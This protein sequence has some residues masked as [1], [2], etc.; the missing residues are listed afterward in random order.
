MKIR[1]AGMLE[2]SLT[3]GK[4]IR[5]VIFGQGCKHNCEECFNRHTHDFNG[6]IEMDTSEIINKINDDIYIDG[7]TFSGGDPFEQAEAFSNIA[8][9]TICNIWC[10]TGYTFEYILEN[11]DKNPGWNDLLNNIDVLVDGK[12]IIELRS[13]DLKYRGSLNQRI[14]DVKKSLELNRVEYYFLSNNDMKIEHMRDLICFYYSNIKK[15]YNII[16]KKNLKYLINPYER[17]LNKFKDIHIENDINLSLDDIKEFAGCCK[18]LVDHLF[19]DSSEIDDYQRFNNL[20]SLYS[21]DID[22]IIKICSNK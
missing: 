13:K 19:I 18:V 4:G 10:Y 21:M 22:S 5:K 11:K 3:N 12:F 20:F 9:S 6:G 8:K 17:R 16:K 14:I 2:N 1:I 7:V 15:S